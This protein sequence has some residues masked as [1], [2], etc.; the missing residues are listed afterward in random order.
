MYLVHASADQGSVC[1]DDPPSFQGPVEVDET[2]IGGLEKNKHGDKKANLGRSPSGK[3][4]V[5]GEKDRASG[6]VKAQVVQRTDEPLLQGFVQKLA[7]MVTVYADDS[8]A[9]IEMSD[10]K[11]ESVKHS[12][13]EYVNGQA[14]T[15]GVAEVTPW[16]RMVG[17]RLK[18]VEI[19]A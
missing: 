6:Q 9:Y 7:E 12:V 1:G 16:Y 11:H 18:F 17:R 5:V 10:V 15:N 8:R 13:G 14:H 19:T 3:A 2:Y 4:E